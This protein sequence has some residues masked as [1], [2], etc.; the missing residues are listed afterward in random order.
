M[1]NKWL[2]FKIEEL[3]A[4]HRV[5]QL[6]A[7]ILVDRRPACKANTVCGMSSVHVGRRPRNDFTTFLSLLFLTP[8][9]LAIELWS[10][11]NYMYI[12][13]QLYAVCVRPILNCD[14]S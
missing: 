5:T 6:V 12:G 11:S 14:T 2:V 9:K 4:L 7:L 10:L 8:Y 3:W 1:I 13:L